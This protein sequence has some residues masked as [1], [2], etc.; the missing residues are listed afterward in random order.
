M[1]LIFYAPEGTR[2]PNLLTLLCLSRSS[3]WCHGSGELPVELAGDVALEAAADFAWGLSFCSASF[4]VGAGAGAA[5]GSGQRD[6]VDGAVQGSVAAAVEPMPHG[7][8]ATG[9]K[10]AGAGQGRERRLITATARVGEAD[11]GLRRSD[12]SDPVPVGQTGG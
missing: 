6:G 11:H 12:G 7:P 5:A 3:C 4:D 8:A 1:A 10:G 2:T 9:R